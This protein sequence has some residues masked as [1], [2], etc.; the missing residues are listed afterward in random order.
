MS[1]PISINDPQYVATQY[2]TAKNLNVRIQLH[3]QFSTNKYGWPR[4]V[5]DQFNFSPQARI[6]ELGCGAGDLW[7]ENIDRV[8]AG[9]EIT[10]SDA[11]AGMLEQAQQNLGTSGRFKFEQ[12]DIQSI[13]VESQSFDG[14]IA[15]HMLYHVPDLNKALGEVRRV[16]KPDGVFYAATM[17]KRHLVEI[18]ELVSRFDSQL[19][20]W[21]A[22]FTESF[23]LERGG[24]ELARWFSD[25]TMR[26][27]DDALVVTEPAALLDY[28]LS[29]RVNL[30]VDQQ[31]TFAKFVAAEFERLGGA[32]HVSKDSGLFVARGRL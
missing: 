27:Y 25:V 15:N 30:T 2:Q 24:N 1:Q 8:P 28:I 11:S 29:G 4:W 13:P 14:V 32:F 21:G 22:G 9:W 17:G 26:R 31:P 6:L 19:S 3:Q 18:A 16:L 5:F 7:R 23:T 20:W 10:L 12:V